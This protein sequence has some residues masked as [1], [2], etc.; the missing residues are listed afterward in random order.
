MAKKP[1]SK[2]SP[3]KAAAKRTK[4]NAKVNDFLNLITKDKAIQARLKKGQFDLMALAR[5]LGYK[6]TKAQLVAEMKRRWG[7]KPP[8]GYP[9]TC[10]IILAKEQ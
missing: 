4:P 6:F 7:K 1:A 9:E 3:R 8:V 2:A 5:G 10:I